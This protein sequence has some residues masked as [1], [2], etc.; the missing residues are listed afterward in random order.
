MTRV[1]T[2][3]QRTQ[4][5]QRPA[6]AQLR[7]SSILDDSGRAIL[8]DSPPTSLAEF[9]AAGRTV[10][11]SGIDAAASNRHTA[12]HFADATG[13]PLAAVLGDDL[14]IVRNRLRYECRNNGDAA[15]MIG[16]LATL[17]VGTGPML[18]IRTGDR[19]LDRLV[20]EHHAD[21]AEDCWFGIRNQ[22]ISDRE[23]LAFRELALAG[24][25]FLT[26]ADDETAA[27]DRVRMRLVPIAPERISTPT[28]ELGGRIRDGVETD[29][30]GRV[31]RYHVSRTHPEDNGAADWARWGTYDV[32]DAADM[33]HSYLHVE[34]GQHRGMPLFSPALGEMAQTRRFVQAVLSAVESQADL[35]VLLETNSDIV[36]PENLTGYNQIPLHRNT[37]ANLPRGY[38]AKGFQPTQPGINHTDYMRERLRSMGRP[39]LF[40]YNVSAGDSRGLTFAGGRM[41]H[42]LLVMAI[43]VWRAWRVRKVLRPCLLR[44]LREAALAIPQLAALRSLDLRRL[45]R[46]AAYVWPSALPQGN[47]LQ[48]AKAD[49][50]RLHNGTVTE[51]SLAA[52]HGGDYEANLIATA[53]CI[54]RRLEMIRDLTAEAAQTLGCD[55]AAARETVMAMLQSRPSA[56]PVSA[57]MPGRRGGNNANRRGAE[58]A[59]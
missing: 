40:P 20:E 46:K 6:E 47:P 30:R 37:I 57:E 10:H 54:R 7:R 55:E 41:D 11:R 36:D 22:S 27:Y 25:D 59:E 8:T 17:A 33:E 1:T 2:E 3:A 12:A 51:A 9:A 19:A 49:T 43:A 15:G 24:E 45:A 50:E 56:T 29:G 16:N 32:V 38:S 35:A 26:Y 18:Q 52:E 4:S 34:C 42:Q 13:R 31:I 48:E 23:A 44:W 21:W 58:D 39:L 28:G 5:G 14:P 53:D